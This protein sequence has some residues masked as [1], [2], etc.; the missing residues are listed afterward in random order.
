M[1]TSLGVTHGGPRGSKAAEIIAALQRAKQ[2]DRTKPKSTVYFMRNNDIRSRARHDQFPA[3]IRELTELGVKAA[4]LNGSVPA[5][6]QDIA[7]LT[8]GSATLGL[9]SSNCKFLPGALL[10]NLTSAAGQFIIPPNAPHPQTPI[11]EFLRAG[12]TGASGC[13]VEPMAVPEKFPSPH[14]HV[15][16]AR[17]CS[18]A[19]AFYQSVAGP[20]QLIIIGDPL[21]QPWATPPTVSVAGVTEGTIIKDKVQ[22]TPTAKYPDRRAASRFELY[23]DGLRKDAIGAGKKFDLATATLADGWHELRVVAIDNTPI[24]VQGAWIGLVQVKNGRDAV[25]LSAPESSRVALSGTLNL[26]V[27]STSKEEAAVFH[28]NRRLGVVAGG[29]GKLAVNAAQLG[30]GRI[31]L[32]VRQ[33]SKPALRSKPLSI[34]VY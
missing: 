12:V 27:T 16:Y 24:A 5:G 19:E 32:Y 2:A 18:L 30:R 9:R 3:A 23:V 7:G 6:K 22:I 31:E 1:A 25:Q 14:L 21:C 28:N 20:A 4:L 15:H 34:E 26:Q 11:S 13:V 29:S 8:T 17:G 33:P 10:D